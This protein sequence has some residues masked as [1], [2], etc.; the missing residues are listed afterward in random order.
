MARLFYMG[1]YS[2]YKTFANKYKTSPTKVIKR[3]RKGNRIVVAANTKNGPKDHHLV[4]VSDFSA[5]E[6]IENADVNEIP[7]LA[8]YMRTT[9]LETKLKAHECEICRKSEG[10]FEA[11]HIRKLKDIKEGKQKW[12]KYMVAR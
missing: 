4:K 2:L 7:N 3:L 1:E 5:F 10:Y 9:E 11:H 8:P 12:K 6:T